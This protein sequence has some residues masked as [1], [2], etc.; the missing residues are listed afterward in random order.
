MVLYPNGWAWQG[1]PSEG[2]KGKDTHC[3]EMEGFKSG[4]KH[5]QVKPKTKSG[6]RAS[7]NSGG[8]DDRDSHQIVAPKGAPNLKTAEPKGAT[9][10]LNKNPL[11]HA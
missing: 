10:L 4:N 6:E 8:I 5:A 11:A 7:N 1:P 3:Q 9:S 2:S